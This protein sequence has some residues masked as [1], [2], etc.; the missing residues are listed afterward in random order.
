MSKRV[1]FSEHRILGAPG[2]VIPVTGNGRR[3][4]GRAERLKEITVAEA[5][6]E[7]EVGSFAQSVIEA[8]IDGPRTRRARRQ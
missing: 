8:H 2:N 6:V 3:G 4:A 7:G 1:R 5:V